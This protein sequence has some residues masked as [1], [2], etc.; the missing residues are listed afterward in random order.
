MAA[1]APLGQDVCAWGKG[2]FPVQSAIP[3][4]S[5]AQTPTVC[6]ATGIRAPDLFDANTGFLRRPPGTLS[7]WAA[8][9]K[10][11][12][13]YRQVDGAVVYVV[14]DLADGIAAQRVTSRAA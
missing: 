6:G 4:F 3:A 10:G 5:G 11:P 2:C 13:Y 14:E 12:I 8:Q 9:R 1:R 7:N